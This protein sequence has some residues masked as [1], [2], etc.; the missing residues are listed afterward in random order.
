MKK[1]IQ[2]L[3]AMML[4]SMSRG[5]LQAAPRMSAITST[6]GMPK[7][8]STMPIKKSTTTA[9]VTTPQEPNNID[10]DLSGF[11]SKA[12]FSAE[13][14]PTATKS[15]AARA[16]EAVKN[17]YNNVG[18]KLAQAT[19]YQ[20]AANEGGWT[21][22]GAASATGTAIAKTPSAVYHA[23]GAAVARLTNN[24][25]NQN[26]MSNARQ[27]IRDSANI[28]N[29]DIDIY[30]DAGNLKSSRSN[31][32]YTNLPV[33]ALDSALTGMQTAYN[34]TGRA[35][36]NAPAN[37][38]SAANATGKALYNA[39]GK[40]GY[41][42]NAGEIVYDQVHDENA[43]RPGWNFSTAANATGRGI[44]NAAGNARQSFN[45]MLNKKSN[46]MTK[47]ASNDSL[48]GFADTGFEEEAD[49]VMVNPGP[50]SSSPIAYSAK[51][52][53]QTSLDDIFEDDGQL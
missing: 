20:S 12:K 26:F 51:T 1:N 17:A 11:D 50:R 48:D 34:A 53:S 42:L 10:Y 22:N 8:K 21:F 45:N 24:P 6:P 16:A 2:I 39:P 9:S 35:I 14:A 47:N 36:S 38:K 37:L 41:K 46:Q 18:G 23:P 43:T 15:Y 13:N 7:I 30:S 40:L 4:L 52:A 33:R 44:S 31:K 5:Y 32:T 29:Q 3:S 25:N 49:F 28:A 19:G 27:S